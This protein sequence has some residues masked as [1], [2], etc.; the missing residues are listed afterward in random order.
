[1]IVEGRRT[2]NELG[3]MFQ[4]WKRCFRIGRSVSE[5]SPLTCALCDVACSTLCGKSS[6]TVSVYYRA[7]NFALRCLYRIVSRWKSSME[8]QTRSWGK[9][10]LPPLGHELHPLTIQSV[11]SQNVLPLLWLPAAGP[12]PLHWNT[13]HEDGLYFILSKIHTLYATRAHTRGVKVSR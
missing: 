4:N 5:S 11:G 13:I 3:E 10:Y 9:Y 1:M 8:L 7:V 2:W 6:S 12:C